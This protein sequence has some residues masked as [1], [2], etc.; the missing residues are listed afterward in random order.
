MTPEFKALR[1]YCKYSGTAR[2]AILRLKYSHDIG[3]GEILSRYLVQL[4]AELPWQIDVVTCVPISRRRLGERGYN[5]SAMLARPLA[6]AFQRPFIPLLLRKTREAP[7]Q[8][9][10]S[11]ENRRKNVEGAFAASEKIALKNHSILVVDDVATT[12]STMNAC[13][14]VL[15]EAGATAVYGLTFARAGLHDHIDFP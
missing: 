9:G 3:L 1:S 7:S 11:A 13:A 4:L 10:M 15:C 12:S 14:R 6:L 2:Q 5:Q 8:V